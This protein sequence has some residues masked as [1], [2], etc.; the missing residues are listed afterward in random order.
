[1]TYSLEMAGRIAAALGALGAVALFAMFGYFGKKGA[2]WAFIAGV[3]LY[4]LDGVMWG[5]LGDW[6]SAG[7]HVLILFFIIRDLTARPRLKA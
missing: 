4:V 5:F 6:I 3:S 7:F 1:M 2:M